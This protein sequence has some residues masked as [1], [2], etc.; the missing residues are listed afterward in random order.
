VL[1]EALIDA[2]ILMEWLLTV[3]RRD[4]MKR[5]G[6]LLCELALRL[7]AAGLSEARAYEV[8]FTQEQIADALGL[9]Q[10]HVNCM[11]KQLERGGLITR[12][13]RSLQIKD[14]RALAERS[15]FDPRYLHL[16]D[17]EVRLLRPQSGR[18]DRSI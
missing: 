7:G 14:W 9:T 15:D 5:V 13:K 8:P 3:G 16:R 1:T 2:S 6:H 10:V 4:A 17:A 11:L 18:G 12:E